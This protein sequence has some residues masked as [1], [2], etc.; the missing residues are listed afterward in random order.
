MKPV[1]QQK[2]GALSLAL[3]RL[4]SLLKQMVTPLHSSEK[5]DSIDDTSV[6]INKTT[7]HLILQNMTTTVPQHGIAKDNSH[8]EEKELLIGSSVEPVLRSEEGDDSEQESRHTLAL[9]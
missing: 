3:G 5:E 6:E 9:K 2:N 4:G 1:S 8:S 7:Y